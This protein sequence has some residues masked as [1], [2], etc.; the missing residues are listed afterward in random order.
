MRDKKSLI[1]FAVGSAFVTSL[2]T[3]PA[4]AAD[5][6]F[7]VQ[8]LDRGYMLAYADRVDPN[9]YG[10]SKPASDAA[11]SAEGN[12]GMSRLDVNKDGKV[13]KQEFLKHHETIFDSI[14]ANKDGAVDQPEADG[15]AGKS[16]TASNPAPNTPPHGAMK[17]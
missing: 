12:C 10:G 9:K 3:A 4:D 15:Y 7:T 2:G 16:G 1:S 8:T 13:T 14:D 6:L 11:K 5:D 17:K